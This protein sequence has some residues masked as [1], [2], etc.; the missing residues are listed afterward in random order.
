MVS[1]LWR[2]QQ[3]DPALFLLLESTDQYIPAF[4]ISGSRL[5]CWG[6]LF[7]IDRRTTGTA[8]LIRLAKAENGI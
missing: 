8:M 7:T 6:D 4:H 1:D 5:S 2:G 3:F